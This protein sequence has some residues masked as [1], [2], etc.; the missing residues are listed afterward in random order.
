MPH[1]FHTVLI[2]CKGF[3]QYLVIHELS[4]FYTLVHLVIHFLRFTGKSILIYHTSSTSYLL[5][6]NTFQGIQFNQLTLMD[7][8]Y[9]VRD[10]L[11]HTCYSLNSERFKKR[12]FFHIM[13]T[14][15]WP[16]NSAC[17]FIQ[18]ALLR[19]FQQYIGDNW[20]LKENQR[21]PIAKTGPIFILMS[22]IFLQISLE[23]TVF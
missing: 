2:Y 11:S 1:L 21:A 17:F 7:K 19:L 9:V 8:R 10:Y 18:S 16:V 23:A 3:V 15:F 5:S 6:S 4:P 20:I 14:V 13:E 12:T 22:D